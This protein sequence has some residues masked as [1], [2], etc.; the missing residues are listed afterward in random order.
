MAARNIS[1]QPRLA[2]TRGRVVDVAMELADASGVRALSMRQIG[3][4][5]GVQAMSLYHYVSG[6]EELL[7]AMVDHV[8]GE[9]GLEFPGSTWQSSLRA[10]AISAHDLFLKH[11]WTCELVLGP[12]LIV[13]SNARLRYIESILARLRGAGFTPQDASHGYHALDSHTLGYTLWEL[14]HRA[15]A[16][17]PDGFYEEVLQQLD[18]ANFHYLIEHAGVH[19]DESNDGLDEFAFGL[20]LILEGLAARLLR[21]TDDEET[22][23]TLS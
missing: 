13:I 11:P 7:S 17:T 22:A 23:P 20:D 16:D 19:F 14:G 8:F 9:V 12:G 2:L 6:K 18:S 1:G 10:T 5:L 21:S 3:D 4:H 15:P